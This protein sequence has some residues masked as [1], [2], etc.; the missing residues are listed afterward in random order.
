MNELKL[1]RRLR[2]GGQIQL[3]STLSP[4]KTRARKGKWHDQRSL[5]KYRKARDTKRRES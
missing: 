3:K 1:A 2:K 5:D 4:N